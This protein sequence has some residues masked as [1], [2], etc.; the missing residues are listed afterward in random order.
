MGDRLRVPASLADAEPTD[1]EQRV[2]DLGKGIGQAVGAVAEIVITTPL[3]V[4]TVVTGQ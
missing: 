3:K 1:G 2:G 4:L